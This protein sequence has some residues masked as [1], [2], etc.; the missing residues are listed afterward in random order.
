MFISR[1]RINQLELRLLDLEN[2]VEYLDIRA[3]VLCEAINDIKKPAKKKTVK[4]TK[5]TKKTK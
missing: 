4:V 5:T 1:K 2:Q 3:D